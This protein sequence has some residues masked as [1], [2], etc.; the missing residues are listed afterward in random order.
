MLGRPPSRGLEWLAYN[1]YGWLAGLSR[2]LE[3][4][5]AYDSLWWLAAAY[6][7]TMQKIATAHN[8]L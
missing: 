8:L 1:P 4:L 3:L 5:T 6:R 2:G 7:N